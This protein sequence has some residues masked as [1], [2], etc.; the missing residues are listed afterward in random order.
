MEGRGG[1][2]LVQ[3]FNAELRRD[4]LRRLRDTEWLNDE[5]SPPTPLSL[6]KSWNYYLCWNCYVKVIN[7]YMNLLRERCEEQGRKCYFFSTFFYPLLCDKGGYNYARV[8]KWTRRVRSFH[9]IP[10]PPGLIY[11]RGYWLQ[12]DLFALDKVVVPVHLGNHWCLAVINVRAKRFEYYDSLASP[13]PSCLGKLRR[14]M[15]VISPLLSTLAGLC[16]TTHT[17]AGWSKTQERSRVGPCWM[18]R[19]AGGQYSSS[20]EWLR[21]WCLYVQICPSHRLRSAIFFQVCIY[22]LSTTLQPPPPQLA[23]FLSVG[24][25][26]KSRGGVFVFVC[27]CVCVVRNRQSDMPHFR[28][29]MIL[30]ILAKRI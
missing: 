25:L 10:P 4:D 16:L 1:E 27:V 14:Y 24:F 15:Q 8:A 20:K 7:F 17:P 21:L 18:G 5:V 11:C 26:S 13:N 2:V 30:Q 23:A 19:Y 29:R 22:T 6:C 3:G 28:K 9:L 12:V